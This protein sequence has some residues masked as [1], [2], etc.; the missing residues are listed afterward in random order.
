MADAGASELQD[1]IEDKLSQVATF[2]GHLHENMTRNFGWFF[3]DMGRRLERAY[4]LSD[5][6]N[7]LFLKAQGEDESNE[8]LNFILK[9]A[10][11]FI[12]YRSRYRLQ[13]MLPLVLDLLVMDEANPRSIAYQLAGLTRHLEALPQQASGNALS[14]ERRIVLG[15]QTSIRLAEVSDLAA[16]DANGLRPAL[17]GLMKQA[18]SDLPDLSDAISRRYFRLVDDEPHRVVFRHEP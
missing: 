7:L 15:L 11:S 13:P 5:V 3:L 14:R 12:T 9:L 18:L 2:S 10:D 1:E 16:A 4:N 6:L 8:D 17:A